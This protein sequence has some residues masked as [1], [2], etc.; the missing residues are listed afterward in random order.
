MR[1][2]RELTAALQASRLLMDSLGGVGVSR[3]LF[4]ATPL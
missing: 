3:A 4:E 2:Q 1:R